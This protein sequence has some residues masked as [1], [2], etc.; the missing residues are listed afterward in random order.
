MFANTVA[1]AG[2]A[3]ACLSYT[4]FNVLMFFVD[5]AINVPVQ[6][7]LLTVPRRALHQ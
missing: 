4:L 6:R 3:E 1:T 7:H 5:F 2:S